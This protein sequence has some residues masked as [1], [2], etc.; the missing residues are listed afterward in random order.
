MDMAQQAAAFDQ[1]LLD[2]YLHQIAPPQDCSLL[3]LTVQVHPTVDSTNRVVWDAIAQSAPEGTVAI[4]LQQT[5][6][7]GQWGRQWQSTQG[8]LYLSV[9]LKPNVAADQAGQLTICSVWG[10]AAALRDRQVPVQI[11]WPND[12]VF[13]RRKV[14]GILTET[15]IAQGR[16]SWAVVGVGLNWDNTVP[17]LGI[18]IKSILSEDNQTCINSLEELAA[19]VLTGLR[20]GYCTWQTNGIEALLPH[21][22]QMLVNLGQPV[23]YQ[24]QT[25]HV[26]GVTPSGGLQLQTDSQSPNIIT[27]EPG[28]LSLGYGG[29]QEPVAPGRVIHSA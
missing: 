19:I 23:E 16:I 27:L 14:G 3:P 22:H 2:E 4:A 21:Y 29:E 7:R 1:N 10:I 12:L 6:G 24:N 15:R 20:R 17:D 5:S 28:D 26:A 25:A 9:A 8:G 13:N 11:K 18:T